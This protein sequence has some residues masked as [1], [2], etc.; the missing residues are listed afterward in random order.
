MNDV[1]LFLAQGVPLLDER[2]RTPRALL[3]EN[4]KKREKKEREREMKEEG[5]IVRGRERRLNK[6]MESNVEK[7]WRGWE[8][9]PRLRLSRS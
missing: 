8:P 1:F 5:K 4:I 2:L 7:R 6:S 9:K 3:S